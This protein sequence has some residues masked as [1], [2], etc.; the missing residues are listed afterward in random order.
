MIAM[1]EEK[2]GLVRVF[3]VKMVGLQGKNDTPTVTLAN[4]QQTEKMKIVFESKE[5]LEDFHYDDA[6]E[7]VGQKKSSQQALA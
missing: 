6:F 3:Y 4:A 7:W 5:A 2:K 1:A